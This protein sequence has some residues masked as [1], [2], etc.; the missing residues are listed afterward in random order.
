MFR[1][2]LAAIARRRGATVHL[3]VGSRSALGYDPLSAESLQRGIPHL[4]EHDVYVCGPDALTQDVVTSLRRARVSR[5]RI[6]HESF[7]Y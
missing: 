6:H 2:E 7:A 3:I 1:D 4:R 5:R